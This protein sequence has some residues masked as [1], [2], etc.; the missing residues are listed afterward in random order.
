M[1]DLAE[2][3]RVDRAI[4]KTYSRAAGASYAVPTSEESIREL[5]PVT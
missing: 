5:E 3:Q 4:L 2:N 1:D